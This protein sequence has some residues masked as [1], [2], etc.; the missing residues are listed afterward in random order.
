M[1][2]LITFKFL[3]KL[4]L[5]NVLGIS[6]KPNPERSK[7]L[8]LVNDEK[9]VEARLPKLLPSRISSKLIVMKCYCKNLRLNYY[10]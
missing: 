4:R 2:L 5:P 1:E 7:L 3:R 10:C 6:V 8:R 9:L